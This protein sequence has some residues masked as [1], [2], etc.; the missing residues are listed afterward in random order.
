MAK[1]LA[2]YKIRCNAL[3]PGIINTP[4]AREHVEPNAEFK[5]FFLSVTPLNRFG[6]SFEVAQ[7]CLFLASSMSSY[8]T[9]ESILYHGGTFC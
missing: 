1:E 7:A 8:M 4:M 2:K 3:A 6:E 5:N 9:G